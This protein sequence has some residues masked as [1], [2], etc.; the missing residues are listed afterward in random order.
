MAWVESGE[1]RYCRASDDSIS[2]VDTLLRAGRNYYGAL[3]A[4]IAGDLGYS[5]DK[6]YIAHSYEYRQGPFLQRATGMLRGSSSGE[7]WCCLVGDIGTLSTCGD[8]VERV[9]GGKPVLAVA[10]PV[11]GADEAPVML[12]ESGG[13]LR[14]MLIYTYRPH[15]SRID[16][17]TLGPVQNGEY[18]ID[19]PVLWH[20]VQFSYVANRG[21]SVV[22]G[23]VDWGFGSG[24]DAYL[25]TSIN[26][27]I[28]NERRPFSP[29]ITYKQFNR[30]SVDVIWMEHVVE[31]AD[32]TYAIM[33]ERMPKGLMTR[34]AQMKRPSAR[35]VRANENVQVAFDLM[36]RRRNSS[37]RGVTIL[38]APHGT[39][40]VLFVRP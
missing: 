37:G 11:H 10:Y 4:T 39:Q 28:R 23:Y 33:H 9:D 2:A 36:G 24:R 29:S 35:H 34:V 27:V 12:Y 5:T 7:E 18:G 21:D 22:H 6:M 32:T 14:C 17:F 26:N 8:H 25:R 38:Q 3:S 13:S 1:I 30:D 16:T 31:G 15:G 40:P 20:G 19:N